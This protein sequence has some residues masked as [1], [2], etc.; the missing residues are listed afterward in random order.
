M[1]PTASFIAMAEKLDRIIA[2]NKM[3]IEKVI[4]EIKV[5]NLNDQFFG[6][7]I[8]ARSIHN[9]HFLIWLERRLF[10]EATIASKL[11]FEITEY[12]LQQNIK[13]SKPVNA[14]SI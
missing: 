4:N 13:T 9:E 12:D 3:I 8:S 7:N 10:K 11:I 14:L 6:I 2:V 5:K 1:L